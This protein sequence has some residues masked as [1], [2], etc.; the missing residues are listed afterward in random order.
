MFYTLNLKKISIQIM[1][2]FTLIELLVV[3]AII[4]ILASML[5]PS[6]QKA[7]RASLFAVCKSNQKQLGI[8]FVN[9][10]TTYDTLP[11]GEIPLG[12]QVSSWEIRIG[13]YMGLDFDESFIASNDPVAPINNPALLCPEDNSAKPNQ[14]FARSY[15]A[16]GW[17][18]WFNKNSDYG[19]ISRDRGRSLSTVK[20]MT[21]LAMES[22]HGESNFKYQ[23]VSWYSTLAQNADYDIMYSYHY[24]NKYNFLYEDGHV[25]ANNKT[26]LMLN[27]QELLQAI[28]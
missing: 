14:G 13:I 5:L 28:D 4:G 9:Y 1:K 7:R 3:V 20:S 10:D 11:Y 8:A 17:G 18:Y 24:K 12:G 15:I 23:G 26:D 25:E 2:R 16:N 21:V 22:H 27:S 19:M 6:L